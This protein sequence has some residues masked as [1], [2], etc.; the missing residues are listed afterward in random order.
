[1]SLSHLCH[2][3]IKW[4]YLVSD[5]AVLALS[6]SYIPIRRLAYSL[7]TVLLS[8]QIIGILQGGKSQKAACSG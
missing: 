3:D 1:M 8:G 4:I 7:L 6:V 5:L 2:K